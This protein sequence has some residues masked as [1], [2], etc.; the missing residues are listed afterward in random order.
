MKSFRLFLLL[1]CCV[2][3]FTSC[4]SLEKVTLEKAPEPKIVFEEL[5]YDF[6]IA[7]PEESISHSFIFTNEGI[8]PLTINKVS[9]DCGCTA[10][11]VSEKVIPSDG[12]GEIRAVFETRRY[13]GE[14]EK[15]IT[16]YSNDPE[17]PEIELIIK[18]VIKRD[19][20]VVPQ[21]INFGDV[22]RGKTAIGS[23][24][25]LQLSS[26]KLVLEK[27]DADKR[28]FEVETSPFTEDNSRGF[29]IHVTLKPDVP[30]G[31]LN[32]VITI[33]TN[34]KKRPRIDVAVWANILGRIRVEPGALSF[35]SVGKGDKFSKAI[36]VS[37]SDGTTFQIVKIECDLPFL[38][39]DTPLGKK[40]SAFE[41]KGKVDK[42]SPAGNVSSQLSIYTDDPDQN[43]IH[44][45]VYGVVKAQ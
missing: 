43:V 24:R 20:A 11:V 13:E 1:V 17:A 40:R 3:L 34:L 27:V 12:I 37:A 38:H 35:G 36:S 6:G 26:Q 32:D 15:H 23:V 18:G 2:T 16:V 7:G 39:F 45:P 8:L 22:E 33:H 41:I 25:L 9:T 10:A 14:Q 30:V 5:E 19:V 42:I 28:Y 4:A 31:R 44:V 21:G 29:N